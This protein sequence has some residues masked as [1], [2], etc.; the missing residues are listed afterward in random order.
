VHA[1]GRQ[2]EGT[3]GHGERRVSTTVERTADV[4]QVTAG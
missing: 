3:N 4:T 1:K 2:F